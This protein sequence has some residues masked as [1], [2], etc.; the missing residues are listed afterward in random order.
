M[1]PAVNSGEP[2][3]WYALLGLSPTATSEQI[4]VIVDRLATLADAESATAP[5][6]SRD[7][8][9]QIAAIRADL[10][11]GPDRRR[12]YDEM[13]AYREWAAAT[14]PRQ[15]ADA[16]PPPPMPFP[17]PPHAGQP[18]PASPPTREPWVLAPV[19]DRAFEAA[20]KI[21]PA[22][23]TQTWIGVQ[24][25]TGAQSATGIDPS[26]GFEPGGPDSADPTMTA[27]AG[28]RAGPGDA[29]AAPDSHARWHETPGAGTGPDAGWQAAPPGRREAVASRAGRTMARL[30]HFLRTAWTCP[31]CGHG[32]LPADRFCQKCGAEVPPPRWAGAEDGPH[33]RSPV[34]PP[35]LCVG[36]GNRITAGNMYCTQCGA[37][38]P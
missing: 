21:R 30:T 25:G 35:V 37:R 1:P 24:A 7:L 11:S 15:P 26:A 6:R 9:L 36:C 27:G 2:E 34:S 4:A 38:R 18:Y 12:R 3:D 20:T 31:A 17:G 19:P 10:L 32:A 14:R 5:E 23:G 29:Q 33:S 22:N 8:Y 28:F 13:L 16:L